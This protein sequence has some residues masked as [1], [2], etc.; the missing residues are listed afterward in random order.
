MLDNAS[1][2]EL[3]NTGRMSKTKYLALLS[4]GALTI[5]L[6]GC[7]TGSNDQ[8]EPTE[9]PETTPVEMTE[10]DDADDSDDSAEKP[11]DVV[12][13]ADTQAG[14][15]AIKAVQSEGG[16]IVITVNRED[17]E[18]VWEISAI[19]GN[20]EVEYDVHADGKIVESER[21][22]A[23]DDD[24]A[25]AAD[26]M[27]IIEAIEKAMAEVSDGYLDEVDLDEDDDNV[28]WEIDFD[29]KSANDLKEVVL[30]YKSG[31]IIST[32]G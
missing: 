19:E 4:A 26:A 20:D 22:S 13:F 10:Q 32:D 16:G 6:A 8:P 12:P 31:E 17:D 3:R 24:K 14:I 7:S 11:D 2:G 18:K 21:E 27:P 23:D 30:H 15:E 25:Y 5:G 29:D 1:L 9:A 28:T